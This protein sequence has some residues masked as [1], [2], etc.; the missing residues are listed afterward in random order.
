L[1]V[2]SEQREFAGLRSKAERERYVLVANGAGGKLA[3]EGIRAALLEMKADA[4]ISTGF[5]G[6]L[7]PE[8]QIGQV[9]AASRVID[10]DS[11]E[12]FAASVPAGFR[13]VTFACED[14]VV[15]TAADKADLRRRTGASAVDM[16]SAAVARQAQS[17]GVPFYCVRV[18]TDTASDTFANDLN[19]ARRPDG[20]LSVSKLVA[21][22]LLRPFSRIPELIR[23]R[24][25]SRRAAIALGESLAACQF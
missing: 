15:Q 7:D 24:R 25:I 18:V 21:Y 23:L 9:V 13:A 1:L 19:A 8:L 12:E 11:G 20:R 5:C 17:I 4:M 22:A 2:A 10:V 6:G 3:A 16:E 14:R